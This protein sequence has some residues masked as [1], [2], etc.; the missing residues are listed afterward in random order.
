MVQTSMQETNVA[1]AIKSM[2]DDGVE[3]ILTVES[4]TG[5]NHIG[6]LNTLAIWFII[7]DNIKGT[8]YATYLLG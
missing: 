1:V 2:V 3:Y 5:S 7:N 8:I 4:L 6:S